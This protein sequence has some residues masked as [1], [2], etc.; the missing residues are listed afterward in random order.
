MKA[1][2]LAVS[3]S[4]LALAALPV[5]AQD[6]PKE[7][8]APGM[9]AA[10]MEAMQ[11]ATAPGA[12][13]KK[14]ARLAGDWTVT[15]RAW[16]APGQPPMESPGTMHGEVL[17]GGRYVEHTWKGSFMGQPFEGRGTDGYDNVGKM[18]VSS[19]VDTMGTGIMHMTGTCDEPVKVCTYTGDVWD[20]MS[21]K[22]TS[23]KEVITWADDNNFKNEMYGPGPDGKEMKWMEITAKRK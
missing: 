2:S 11:K 22:K 23:M 17:M 8:A 4:L 18:Y 10:D 19:W 16:M 5:L 15:T 6:K 20:P 13:Q 12:Q 21:G 14:L 9:G 7:P 1:R 3:L